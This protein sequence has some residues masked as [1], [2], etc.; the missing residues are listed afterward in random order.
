MALIGCGYWGKNLLR[1]MMQNPQIELVGVVEPSAEALK[2][3]PEGV[4]TYSNLKELLAKESID[5]AAIATPP[6]THFELAMSLLQEGIPT[7]VEKPLALSSGHVEKLIDIATQKNAVLMVDHTYCYS[8]PVEYLGDYIS[9]GNLG[10][11]LYYDSVRV[12]LGGFQPTTNVLWDLAPH[13][14]SILDIWANKKLPHSV[15]AI[16]KKHYGSSTE[17]ICYV[18]LD[19]EGD[20]LAHL[21]INW[22]API[23]TRKITV[24]GTQKMA[25]YDDNTPTEKIR[26]Y[27]QRVDFDNVSPEDFKINYRIGSMEAPVIL[28]KEPLTTMM[29]HFVDC[30]AKGISPKTDGASAWRITKILEAISA[31]MEK[32]GQPTKLD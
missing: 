28:Q 31:S 3:V 17:N 22:A 5:G 23:K 27:D 18:T 1:V 21:S 11:L 6:S 13:D 29:A 7:L 26:I 24:T 16:G 32:G 12:N 2:V 9:R 25:V 20:F 19:Y 10:D 15:V 4:S 30:I 14:L 8:P